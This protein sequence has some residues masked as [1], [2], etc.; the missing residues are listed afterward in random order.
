MSEQII[1]C[2]VSASKLE[3]TKEYYFD[4]QMKLL[5]QMPQVYVPIVFHPL[6]QRMLTMCGSVVFVQK[7]DIALKNP[8]FALLWKW[9]ACLNRA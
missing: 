1:H 6:I 8:M 3:Y 2:C 9:G 7:D 5:D 4:T